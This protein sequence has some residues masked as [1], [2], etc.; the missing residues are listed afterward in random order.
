MGAGWWVNKGLEVSSG[1]EV[2]PVPLASSPLATAGVAS[3]PE[4]SPSEGVAERHRSGLPAEGAPSAGLEAHS[5]IP[6]RA[7]QYHRELVR[8][9]RLVWGLDAPVARFAAQ[10][11]QESAWRPNAESPYAQGLAQFTP[12]TAEWI[13]GIYGE[14]AE[15]APF[16]PRWALAALV[17]YDHWLLKRVSERS[18]GKGPLPACDRWAMT[19]SAYNGGLGWVKRDRKLAAEA[20]ADSNRWWGEVEHHTGRADWAAKENREYPRRILRR[21]EPIYAA[22]NWGGRPVC[23][24]EPT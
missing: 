24:G 12:E 15:A 1:K 3:L 11:H 2:A 4:D 20:G 19:M 7:H 23:Q 17:R 10:I 6:R 21:W 22:A 18:D 8:Q 5:K 16:S 9:A 14:L 13:S